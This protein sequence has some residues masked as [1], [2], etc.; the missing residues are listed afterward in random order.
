LPL[1]RLCQKAIVA[2]IDENHNPEAA[3]RRV[4]DVAAWL[5]S[6]GVNAAAWSE[7]LTKT[8]ATQLDA[9]ADTEVM[10]L[11]VT[12]AYGHAK[13]REWVFGGVTRDLLEQTSR[14]QLLAH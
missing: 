13:F 3:N 6:H 11:I 4:E 9:L 2:E 12:G 8:A 1:L 10:D 7:P 14:C 5:A